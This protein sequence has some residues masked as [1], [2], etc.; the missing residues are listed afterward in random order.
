MAP[1]PYVTD[2]LNDVPGAPALSYFW[3]RK[4]ELSLRLLS[5][6]CEFAA[7]APAPGP[8]VFADLGC[9]WATDLWRFVLALQQ[10]EATGAT[11]HDWR[12]IGV[13]AHVNSLDLAR[14]RMDRASRTVELIRGEF[15]RVIPLPDHSV[16][17][18]Y[19]SE[20]LEHMR[21]P[22]P[23]IAEWRRVLRPNGHVLVTTPNEPNVFQRSFY[24]RARRE[25]NRLALRETPETI[26]DAEGNTFNYYGHI[27]I[28]RIDEWEALF[29]TEGLELVD[30][31]RGALF[32]GSPFHNH[33]AV[34]AAQRVAEAVLDALPKALTRFISDQLIGLYRVR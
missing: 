17:V 21:D 26:T 14:R 13:D 8:R 6:H 12:V 11:A 4:R 24:S 25:A 7:P 5:R 18:I 16:D 32:Y 20:V 19:C 29:T 10:F 28:R 33:P 15:T 30:F 3:H 1:D 23:F 27:G 22:M 31:E 9:G 34:F 2:I